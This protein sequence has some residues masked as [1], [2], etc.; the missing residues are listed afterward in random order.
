MTVPLKAIIVQID[1]YV[2]DS[3]Y[4]NVF[5]DAVW[6]SSYS[7]STRWL[8][9]TVSIDAAILLGTTFLELFHF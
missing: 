1:G 8:I 5:A 2:C 4:S 9:I 7:N 3:S 6:V